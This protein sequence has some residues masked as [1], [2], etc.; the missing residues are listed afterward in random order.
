MTSMREASA[1]RISPLI[2]R[3]LVVALAVVAG[4]VILS[5]PV[6]GWWDQR[7]RLSTAQADLADIE[8]ENQELQARLESISEPAELEL[9]AREN[10]GMVREGEESYT[11]LPPPTAGL[12]LP[13]AWPF[14]RLAT[15][16]E[17]AP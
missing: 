3:M 12:A 8:S 14:N 16:L 13:N 9:L 15:A 7:E 11:V 17:S 10:L 1:P 2:K 6:S 4:Y 5:T